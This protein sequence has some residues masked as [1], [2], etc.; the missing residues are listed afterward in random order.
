MTESTTLVYT[1]V[2]T[3]TA[4]S[5]FSFAGHAF[6][7]DAYR[8]G[9]LLPGFTFSGSVTV[10][11]HYSDADVA[12]LDE[13]SLVLEYWNGSAWVDAACGDY[14]RHPGENWLAVPICHLSRFALFERTY[15]VYLPLL[16]RRSP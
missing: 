4:L 9:T 15:T 14:D 1:P 3:A 8:N 16:L 6:D 11:L 5:G 2:D 10:T 7:L 13:D 12:G